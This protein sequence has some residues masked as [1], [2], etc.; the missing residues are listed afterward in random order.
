MRLILFYFLIRIELQFNIIASKITSLGGHKVQQT[1]LQII[2][3]LLEFGYWN[4]PRLV[5]Y[6][7][8]NFFTFFK[9]TFLKVIFQSLEEEKS[10]RLKSG[11]YGDWLLCDKTHCRDVTSNCSWCLVLTRMTVF[12]KFSKTSQ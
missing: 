2:I 9:M 3:V 6:N 7:R 11:K 4:C 8:L 5:G 10:Q 12:R 1:L